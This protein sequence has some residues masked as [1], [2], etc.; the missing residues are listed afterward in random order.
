MRAKCKEIEKQQIIWKVFFTVAEIV[1]KM[2]PL[3]FQGIEGFI[4]DLPSCPAAFYQIHDIVPGNGDI[5]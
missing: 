5:G 2:V 1:L 3:I 4:F